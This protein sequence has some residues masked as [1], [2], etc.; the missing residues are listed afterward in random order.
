MGKEQ[1]SSGSGNSQQ[2]QQNNNSGNQQT[3]QNNGGGKQQTQQSGGG[4]QQQTQQNTNQGSQQTVQDVFTPS[5]DQMPVAYS[6]KHVPNISNDLLTKVTECIA[7][8]NSDCTMYSVNTVYF[9]G[10]LDLNFPCLEKCMADKQT[11][12]ANIAMCQSKC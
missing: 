1:Q 6:G 11:L 8:C 3:Q 12:C 7:D 5:A 9:D 10:V 2:T 4:N